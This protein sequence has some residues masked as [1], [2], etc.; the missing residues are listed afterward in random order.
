MPKAAQTRLSIPPRCSVEHNRAACDSDC[1][2]NQPRWLADKMSTECRPGWH[3]LHRRSQPRQGSGHYNTA[4]KHLAKYVAQTHN[5][6]ARLDFN[7]PRKR[8][9]LGCQLPRCNPWLPGT[10][11]IFTRPCLLQDQVPYMCTSSEDTC[12]LVCGKTR[13]KERE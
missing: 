2:R 5:N 11:W 6:T 7:R 4:H 3:K 10:V 9:H 12:V 13:G 8:V 1:K